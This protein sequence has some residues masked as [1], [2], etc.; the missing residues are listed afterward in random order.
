LLIGFI[1]G[2]AATGGVVMEERLGIDDPVGAFPTHALA[3]IWGLIATGLFCENTPEFAELSGLFKGGEW[4][5]L[6]IQILGT[7]SIILWAA[8]TTFIQLYIID[9]IFGLRM[10]EVEEEVGADYYVHNICCEE[11]QSI[12]Y[13][14]NEMIEESE[15]IPSPQFDRGNRSTE[16]NSAVKCPP[17]DLRNLC[18]INSTQSSG[19]NK[20]RP[21][22]IASGNNEISRVA[23]YLE[24]QTTLR[25]GTNNCGYYSA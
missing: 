2:A 18:E 22:S 11:G 24:R 16:E 10:T 4:K 23:P 3:S 15:G 12:A 14:E 5:F 17:V 25:K 8:V 1:G 9:K 19:K 6:G 21:S 7:V 13:T 20:M